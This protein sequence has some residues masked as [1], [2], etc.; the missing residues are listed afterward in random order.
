MHDMWRSVENNSIFS[1]ISMTFHVTASSIIIIPA[2]SHVCYMRCMD[3]RAI[4]WNS[5][6]IVCL[7]LSSELESLKPIAKLV[8]LVLVSL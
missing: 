1:L 2:F 6:I 4:Q 7:A 5:Q 8:M 3:I